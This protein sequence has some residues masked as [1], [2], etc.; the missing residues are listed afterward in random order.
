MQLVEGLGL[1]LDPAVQ[2]LAKA[3]EQTTFY[4]TVSLE[5]APEITSDVLVAWTAGPADEVTS[6]P[7]Y[8]QVPALQRGSAVV[9]DDAAFVFGASAVSVLSVPWVLDQL[10]DQLSAAVEKA[11]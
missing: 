11:A 9:V 5:R 3:G 2:D 4:S 7:I 1:T 6:L 10:V 8:T